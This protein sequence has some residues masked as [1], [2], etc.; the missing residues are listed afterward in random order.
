ML[1]VKSCNIKHNSEIVFRYFA[2]AVNSNL[3]DVI[4]KFFMLSVVIRGDVVN[5]KIRDPP[6]RQDPS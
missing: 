2:R 6:R 1:R 3:Q 4:D 5:G